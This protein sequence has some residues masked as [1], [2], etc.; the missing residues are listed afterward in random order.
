[1]AT[2]LMHNGV[3]AAGVVLASAILVAGASTAAFAAPDETELLA[4]Q[5]DAAASSVGAAPATA[6]PDG[7]V[8]VTTPASAAG[9]LVLSATDGPTISV[10]L[11]TDAPV[12]SSASDGATVYAG[13]GAAVDVAIHP[14]A[15][16]ARVATI[17]SEQSQPTEYAYSLP[18]DVAPRLLA[19]GSVEL[20]R[21]ADAVDPETGH[22]AAISVV[23]GTA[24]AAWAIDSN[25]KDVPTRYVVRDNNLV[26][27]VDHRASGIA[28]PVV[29]D[30]T[31]HVITYGFQ[32][33][34]KW[35]R[36]ETAAIASN[37]FT[38][39]AITAVCIAAGSAV[40][41]PVVLLPSV[42]RAS[43]SAVPV[44]T[45]PRSRRT[46]SPSVASSSP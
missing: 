16:G 19:D 38:P 44:L 8:T 14:V 41:G 22:R 12:A 13:T 28:Y 37:G 23:I 40:G 29:A 43:P 4:A 18:D 5:A 10:G 36:A 20:V 31:Y 45:P 15:D 34:V 2:R 25:G 42:P 6:A 7:E 24:D 33:L 30:P 3:R 39:A 21:T 9:D 26:Q 17:I 46:R 1:M 32:I 11:P 35:N 27:I